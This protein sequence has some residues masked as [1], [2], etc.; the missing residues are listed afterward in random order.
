[1][2]LL[3]NALGPVAKT[4]L[5]ASAMMPVLK[6]VMKFAEA[7]ALKAVLSPNSGPMAQRPATR[8]H[9]GE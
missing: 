5:E 4:I 6:E 7:D 1:M 8:A 2:P 3:G 9:E